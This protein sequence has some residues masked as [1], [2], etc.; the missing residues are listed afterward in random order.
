MSHN[1][2]D[3][4]GQKFG[5]LAA[6]ERAANAPN[7]KA[8]W[9]CRCDCGSLITAL[10]NNLIAGRSTS[11]GCARSETIKRQLTR[12]GHATDGL[13]V[14]YKRWKSIKDRCCNPNQESYP[15]YGGRGIRV[16][17]RWLNDFSAFIV[18]M[19]PIPSP[20]H[21]IERKDNSLGYSPENCV[22]ATTVEQ[23]NNRSNNRVLDVHGAQYTMAE[24]CR[25]YGA[26]YDQVK[27]R[28]R[29]GWTAEEALG[30][31]PRENTGRAA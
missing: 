7:G 1:F 3:I 22:W 27:G 15:L 26:P 12:H 5:R 10:S 29:R 6:V 2:R 25:I 21:T 8:R 19:G 9:F 20:K 16:C 17:D 30:L 28:I 18:D 11:C 14:E 31:A 24:A 4:A 23:A 13:S